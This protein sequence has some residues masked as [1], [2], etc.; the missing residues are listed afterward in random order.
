MM[1]I[2][3]SW[4]LNIGNC[5]S[6][7]WMRKPL[8][9]GHCGQNIPNLRIASVL[10]NLVWDM[11]LFLSRP[12][13]ESNQHPRPDEVDQIK[14]Q[15]ICCCGGSSKFFS[16]PAPGL[17]LFVYLQVRR[18]YHGLQN[19]NYHSLIRPLSRASCVIIG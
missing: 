13:R 18:T 1:S 19:C 8:P 17:A 12:Y 4:D 11:I 3:G 15:L 10:L 14:G 16:A 7:A 6:L 2:L 5:N 9:W